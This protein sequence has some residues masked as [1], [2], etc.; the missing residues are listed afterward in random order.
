M[1]RRYALEEIDFNSIQSDCESKEKLRRTFDKLIDLIIRVTLLARDNIST[2]D[3]LGVSAS[4]VARGK[5]S[6]KVSGSAVVAAN[7]AVDFDN[8]ETEDFLSPEAQTI[9]TA[10]WLTMKEVGLLVGALSSKTKHTDLLSGDALKHLGEHLISVMLEVKHAGAIDKTRIG[11]TTLCERLLDDYD[12]AERNLSALP[13]RWLTILLNEEIV[14]KAKLSMK[15]RVRRSAGIPFAFLAL[16][17]SEKSSSM[18]PML[19]YAIEELFKVLQLERNDEEELFSTQI[20]AFNVLRVIF[21]DRDLS[22]ATSIYAAQGAELC[23]NGMG[24]TPQWEVRPYFI[25]TSFELFSATYLFY[26]SVFHRVN[27]CT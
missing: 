21:K 12:V 18:R 5:D 27:K 19:K 17:L 14:N 7:S 1:L 23:I 13:M 11:L 4:E 25:L 22:L 20:H 3:M 2:P 10:S 9:V 16:L 26:T 24:A 15:D 8:E 6:S